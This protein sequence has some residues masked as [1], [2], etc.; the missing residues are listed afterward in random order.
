MVEMLLEEEGLKAIVPRG[1]DHNVCTVCE[2]HCVRMNEIKSEIAK[3]EMRNAR[4]ARAAGKSARDAGE[5]ESAS[6]HEK[7]PRSIDG[8]EPSGELSRERVSS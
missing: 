7:S 4:R 2:T 3:S 1:Y 8:D 6:P 5:R